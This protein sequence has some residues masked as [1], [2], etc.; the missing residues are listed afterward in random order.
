MLRFLLFCAVAFTSLVT[1]P[2]STYAEDKLPNIVLIFM[3][4]K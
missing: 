4:D 2:T 3:D 1:L